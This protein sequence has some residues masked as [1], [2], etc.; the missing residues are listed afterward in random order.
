MTAASD[1]IRIAELWL[2]RFTTG[3]FDGA[4]ALL[5]PNVE[6][7]ALLPDGP[8]TYNGREEVSGRFKWWFGAGDDIQTTRAEARAVED[9]IEVSYGFRILNA[10]EGDKPGWHSVEQRAFCDIGTTIERIDVVCSGYRPI[11]EASGRLHRFDA[12][13]MGCGDGLP[14]EFRRWVRSIAFG[15]VMEVVTKDP[16]AKEDLPSL[17]RLMGNTVRSIETLDDGRLLISVEREK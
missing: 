13:D 14:Q 17:A 9:R 16:A 10:A 5:D 4:A 7:R 8:Q 3:D 12:G 1:T 6:M 2:D 15:D 11:I